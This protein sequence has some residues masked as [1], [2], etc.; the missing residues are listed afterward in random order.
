MFQRGLCHGMMEGG[1]PPK[2]MGLL[3]SLPAFL[4][5]AP[6][7]VP[8]LES[9]SGPQPPQLGGHALQPQGA[10][11]GGPD[12]ITYELSNGAGPLPPYASVSSPVKGGHS[13]LCDLRGPW[14]LIHKPWTNI[15]RFRYISLCSDGAPA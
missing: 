15:S 14:R 8:P 13:S 3:V 2:H 4:T 12:G 6:L 1:F 5:R 7:S 10:A 9:T 11:R